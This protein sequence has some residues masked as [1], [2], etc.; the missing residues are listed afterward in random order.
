MT[1]LQIKLI[2]QVQLDAA[3]VY[4]AIRYTMADT[5]FYLLTYRRLWFGEVRNAV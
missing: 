3:S 5:H 1:L 4:V 2:Y